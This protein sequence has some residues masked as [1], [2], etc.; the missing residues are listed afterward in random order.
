VRL[1]IDELSAGEVTDRLAALGARELLGALDDLGSRTCVWTPQDETQATYAPKIEKADVALAPE[2]SVSDA[3]RRVRASTPQAPSRL[4]LDG[5]SVTVLAVSPSHVAASPGHV[6]V[7][8]RELIAGFA[9]GSLALVRVRPEGRS[10]M[11]GADWARG[12][13]I[14]DDATWNR[15]T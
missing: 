9:D 14:A 11:S 12:T 8:K 10:D 2:L 7:T 3:W 6:G 15:P 13:R 5:R 4:S 1:D